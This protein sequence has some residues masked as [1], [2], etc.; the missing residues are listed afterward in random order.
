MMCIP[1]CNYSFFTWNDDQH[2]SS[3]FFQEKQ[4]IYDQGLYATSMGLMAIKRR[5]QSTKRCLCVAISSSCFEDPV[6]KTYRTLDTSLGFADVRKCCSSSLSLSLFS[7]NQART[8]K[9]PSYRGRFSSKVCLSS[10][11][12]WKGKCPKIYVV[13][14]ARL[15]MTLNCKGNYSS[16]E[17]SK[18]KEWTAG[19]WFPTFE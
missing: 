17:I 6:S 7:K 12:V 18:E 4:W 1:S 9:V 13:S 8:L 14:V 19:V 11:L 3:P 5:L 10:V 16:N 2:S 15:F